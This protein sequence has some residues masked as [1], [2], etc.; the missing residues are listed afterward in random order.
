MN[1]EVEWVD[2][3]PEDVRNATLYALVIEWSEEDDAFVVSVPDLPGLHTHGTT[4]E[5]AATMGNEVVAFWLAADRAQGLMTPPPSF[6][7]LHPSSLRVSPIGPARIRQ[8]RHR[9]NVSQQAF[10]EILN[11]SV[12]TVRSWEQGV[13]TP[14]G[15]SRR[16]LEIAEREPDALLK[17]AS[18][19]SKAG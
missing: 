11:V 12:G 2:V 8:L 14:D 9:L 16:L 19:A 4:R 6:S 18:L 1:G 3:T 13:R 15:A 7:A 17:V 5:E 10:A